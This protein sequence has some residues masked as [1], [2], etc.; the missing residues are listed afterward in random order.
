MIFRVA[1]VATLLL[2]SACSSVTML[3]AGAVKPVA[4]TCNV[5]VY[6]TIKQAEK[7]GAI[8]ELCIVT[9]TSSGSFDHS[10][11]TAIGKHKDKVCQ[12]GATNAYIQSRSEGG[13]DLA[14]V[15]LVGFRYK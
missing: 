1:T 13:M 4:G 8:E 10:V 15:T 11:A 6:Q 12:C 7:N 14:T 3:D 5:T 2:L 9:G